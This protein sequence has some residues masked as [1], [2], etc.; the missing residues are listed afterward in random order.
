M[1]NVDQIPV[2]AAYIKHYIS[3]TTHVQEDEPGVK[4]V[5]GRDE[6]ESRHQNLVPVCKQC[7]VKIC[8]EA[9][10]DLKYKGESCAN[11]LTVFR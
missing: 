10:I 1:A 2:D 5:C 7:F 6:L 4:F 11:C 3:R 9:V 8:T